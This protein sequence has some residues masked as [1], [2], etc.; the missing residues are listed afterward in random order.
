MRSQ[1]P[2]YCIKLESDLIGKLD[3][4]SSLL[5]RKSQNNEHPL[6]LGCNNESTYNLYRF[7]CWNNIRKFLAISF[8][9]TF[10]NYI[11]I[12]DLT[13]WQVKTRFPLSPVALQSL[14]DLGRLTY[15]RFLELFRH[16]VGLLGWVISP[17]QGL[18]LHRTTQ[19]KKTRTNIHALTKIRTHDPSNQPAKTHASDRRATVTGK[20]RFY[21]TEICYRG[22]LVAGIV[23]SNPAQ[24]M[25]VCPRHSVLCCP[26]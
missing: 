5:Q 11:L 20:T 12:V 21:R 16:M 1:R 10:C 14:K 18:Y 3:T 19:H 26:V 17:S 15:R 13:A 9:F 25:D 7:H 4:I 2:C 8:C 6:L 22:R 24:G 23:G